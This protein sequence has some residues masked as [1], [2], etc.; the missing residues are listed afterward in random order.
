MKK[1]KPG[2]KGYMLLTI[3]V[4]LMSCSEKTVEGVVKS[5]IDYQLSAF[6]P[7]AQV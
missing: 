6:F 3:K 2:Y 1:A 4:Y 7:L 5:A